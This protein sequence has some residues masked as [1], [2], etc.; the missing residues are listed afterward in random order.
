MVI[1]NGQIKFGTITKSNYQSAIKN[2]NTLYFIYDEDTEECQIAIGSNLISGE[3]TVV[4]TEKSAINITNLNAV[5]GKA[6]YEALQD[7]KDIIHAAGGG[8]R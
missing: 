4:E 1:P 2:N 8:P 7:T 3:S 5:A 6:V